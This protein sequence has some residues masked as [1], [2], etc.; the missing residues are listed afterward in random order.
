M[1]QELVELKSSA[2]FEQHQQKN[3]RPSFHGKM[4]NQNFQVFFCKEGVLFLELTM[5]R[6]N[7]DKESSF[8]I[9]GVIGALFFGMFGAWMGMFFDRLREDGVT[10]DPNLCHLVSDEELFALAKQRKRSFVL[11]NDE[12]KSI[13]IIGAPLT[14][15]LFGSGTVQGRCQFK[16]RK[17]GKREIEIRD[18]Q[19]MQA[20][21]H[22][23]SERFNELTS[24][25]ARFDQGL[26]RFVAV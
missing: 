21:I 4:G 11:F 18:L 3:D 20:A 16:A 8:P 5:K 24:V 25:E 15:R 10:K 14:T 9:L 17:Q 13:R 23:C 26:Q 6:R 2:L 22:A 12:L 1:V 19:S 7:S